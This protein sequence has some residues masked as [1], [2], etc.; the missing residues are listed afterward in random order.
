MVSKIGFERRRKLFF[1]PGFGDLQIQFF[2]AQ[3]FTNWLDE[4]EIKCEAGSHVCESGSY[5]SHSGQDKKKTSKKTSKKTRF[6]LIKN[7]F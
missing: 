3:Y 4:R 7:R 6:F 5:P 1:F 2:K